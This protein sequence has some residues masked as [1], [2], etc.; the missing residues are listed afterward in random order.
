MPP[1]LNGKSYTEIYNYIREEGFY[2][3]ALK[4]EETDIS[5]E[6]YELP[7]QKHINRIF[8]GNQSRGK[9]ISTL[10]GLPLEVK[11]GQHCE[12]KTAQRRRVGDLALF[13]EF[14]LLKSHQVLT[15]KAGE[16][17]PRHLTE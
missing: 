9:K 1:H 11:S 16:N 5:V 13:R 15:G 12:I 7:E 3:S 14:F 4:S 8:H 10:N 17:S 6:N 2:T